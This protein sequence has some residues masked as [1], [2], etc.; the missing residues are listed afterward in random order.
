MICKEI[1]SVN[2]NKIL[3]EYYKLE[4]KIDWFD[5]K[6]K[7]K[8]CGLQYA[9]GEDFFYSATGK[10]KKD[11]VESEYCLINPL[12]KNTIFEDLINKYKMFRTRLMWVHPYACYSIHK[13]NSSRIHVPLITN[14]RCLFLFPDEPKLVHLQIGKVFLVDTTI[15]H[16]FCNFSDHS[17]LHIVGCVEN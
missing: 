11:R 5:N 16:S 9:D 8:Q 4:S 17:R 1:D 7:G 12:F 13:D 3:L 15:N 10:L 6:A 2:S 14:D